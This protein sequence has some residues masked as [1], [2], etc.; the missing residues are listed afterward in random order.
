[1]S[2]LHLVSGDRLTA[3]DVYGIWKIRDIVFAVEQRCDEPDVDGL[4][5]LPTTTHLWLTDP[6]HEDGG[7]VSYLR[8][9]THEQPH[10]LGRVCT[11]REYRGRGLSSRLVTAAHERWGHDPVKI[12][13]QAYL[14]DWYGSH[15]YVTCGD[16]YTDAGIDHVPMLRPGSGSAVT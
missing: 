2:D 4:D 14:E 3:A 15:G 5:L 9:L 7:P 1:V 11:L 8:F 13:A 6:G 12:G 16:H 10:R